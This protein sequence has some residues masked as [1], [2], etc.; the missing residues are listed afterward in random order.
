MAAKSS[1]YIPSLDGIRAV[2]IFIVFLSHAGLGKFIPGGLGVSIF[3]FLSGY[4][5]TTLLRI[6]FDKTQNISLKKFYLR[7]IIRISPPAYLVGIIATIL[8]MAGVLQGQINPTGVFSQIF[9]WSNYYIIAANGEGIAPGTGVFWSLAVEEHFYLIFPIVYILLQ[10]YI[11]SRFQQMLVLFGVCAIVLLWRCILVY[12]LHS[13]EFRTFYATDTRLDSILFGS[14]LGIYGNPILDKIPNS[15]RLWMFWFGLSVTVLL[16]SVLHRDPQFRETFRYTIQGIALFPIF[17]AAIL[18]HKSWLIFR[19]LNLNWVKFLGKIS[20]S[21]YLV[22]FTIIIWFG[23]MGL[24]AFIS[25][26][27]ALGLS[28]LVSSG[29]YYFVEKPCVH[30]R[31]RL[32]VLA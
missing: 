10:H 12:G 17:I 23:S 29:I 18:Y 20:Y 3:F 26:I 30:L 19:F 6:E 14:I 7:R 27:F 1:F 15:N 25:G 8:T 24:P 32:A 16:L 4:L 28:L 5:I 31:H 21:L 13:S 22:H 9:H 2:S 11:P